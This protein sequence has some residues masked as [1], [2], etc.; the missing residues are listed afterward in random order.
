VVVN[1][2]NLIL[3]C[4][5]ILSVGSSVVASTDPSQTPESEETYQQRIKDA[6]AAIAA[7]KQK[8]IAEGDQSEACTHEEAANSVLKKILQACYFLGSAYVCEAPPAPVRL[9]P[10]PQTITG[11]AGA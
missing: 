8:C 2:R 10:K 6:Q 7:R 11:G 5:L 3:G 4:F 9:D 1:C